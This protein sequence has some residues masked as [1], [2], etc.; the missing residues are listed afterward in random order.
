MEKQIFGNLI[1]K[2]K[3]LFPFPKK[4]EEPYNIIYVWENKKLIAKHII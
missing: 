3:S 1:E 2:C 4:K